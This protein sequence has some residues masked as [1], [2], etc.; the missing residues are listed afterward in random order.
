MTSC[1]DGKS[2]WV[3]VVNLP[4]RGEFDTLCWKCGESIDLLQELFVARVE[5]G[6]ERAEFD[7]RYAEAQ[8]KVDEM[9]RNRMDATT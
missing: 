5:Y 9:I 6:I 7:R 2:H 4:K 1:N 8:T 3:V